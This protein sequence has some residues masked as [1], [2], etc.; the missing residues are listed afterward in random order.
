MILDSNH[1]SLGHPQ[2]LPSPRFSYLR[3]STSYTTPSQ[4]GT[5]GPPFWYEEVQEKV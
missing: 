4:P 5:D 1:M 2:L 3:L